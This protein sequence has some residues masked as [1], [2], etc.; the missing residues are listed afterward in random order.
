MPDRRRLALGILVALALRPSAGMAQAGPR[1]EGPAAVADSFF[2]A[3][4]DARWLDAARLMD[5]DAIS[6]VRDQTVRAARGKRRVTVITPEML[7]EHNPKMPREVAEYEARV[8]NERATDF[9]PVAYE[10]ANVPS[11]DSLARLPGVDVAARWLE[12]RDVRWGVRRG[13]AEYQKQGCISAD[14]VESIVRRMRPGAARIVGTVVDD[15]LAYVLNERGFMDDSDAES[16]GRARPRRRSAR[17]AMMFPPSV[18]ILRRVGS[19]WRVVP[20][21]DSFAG[22]AFSDVSGCRP[23]APR[24]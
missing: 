23:S 15:S 20:S 6:A 11:I 16:A 14:S 18:V 9:D 8:S 1:L 2:Q 22:T 17:A 10:Y 13:L 5:L 7:L 21:I 4:R 3:T 19:E 12:A 24:K